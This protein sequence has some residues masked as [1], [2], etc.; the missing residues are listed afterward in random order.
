MGVWNRTSAPRSPDT[1]RDEL[2]REQAAL[3][4]ELEHL[5]SRIAELNQS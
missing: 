5:R 3:E 1:E 2:Q 4:T